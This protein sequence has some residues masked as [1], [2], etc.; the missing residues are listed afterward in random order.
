MPGAISIVLPPCAWCPSLNPSPS[1]SPKRLRKLR[2]RVAPRLLDIV[3]LY[4][5]A[6]PPFARTRETQ[7]HVQGYRVYDSAAAFDT[8]ASMAM[9][10]TI[11]CVLGTRTDR[12][13]RD[14]C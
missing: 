1:P 6:C 7:F 3:Q 8:C 2:A 14:C 10:M 13:T 11:S 4:R 5:V 9:T 12:N